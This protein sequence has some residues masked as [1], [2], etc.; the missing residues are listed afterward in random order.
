MLAVKAVG[1]WLGATAIGLLAARRI[2]FVLKLLKDPGAIATVALGLALIVSGLF[3]QAGLA[4]IV[5][6]Y[7]MGLSLSR[8]DVAHMVRERLSPVYD[9]LVPVF[10]CVTGMQID[11]TALTDPTLLGFG[12]IYSAL[13]LAAKVLGCGLPALLIGFNL[14]GAAR[15]GFGM[16]PRGEVGLIVAGIAVSR[17]FLDMAGGGGER[18]LAAVI[19]MIVI[20]TVIAPPILVKLMGGTPGTKDP[21]RPAGASD[22][23]KFDFPSIDLATFFVG[24]INRLF[25]ADGYFAH[26]T[27]RQLHRYQLRRDASVIDFR[28]E[29]RVLTFRCRKSDATMVNAVMDE[30]LARLTHT[31]QTL[32]APLDTKRLRTGMVEDAPREGDRRL[33]LRRMRP[34]VIALPLQGATVREVLV[35]LVEKLEAAGQ[36]LDAAEAVRAVCEREADLP[37]GMEHGVALPHARTDAVDRLVCALGVSHAGVEFKALDGQLTHLVFLSLSPAEEPAPLLELMA[38]AAGTLDEPRRDRI[39]QASTPEEV[40]AALNEG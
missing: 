17:G 28:R 31:L 16:A 25:E 8:A 32:R 14:K 22:E 19:L 10:F 9:L 24:T 33:L 6:A 29:G 21:P 18:L 4:M 20:N 7:V 15:I 3:E 23:L 30:A 12:L 1:V 40:I 35:E 26:V 37:T 5:G 36:V 2:G 13:A 27:D 39:L 11:L 38:Q 34:A